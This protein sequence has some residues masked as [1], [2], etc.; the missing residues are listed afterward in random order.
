MSIHKENINLAEYEKLKAFLQTDC[1]VKKQEE[2]QSELI[3]ASVYSVL[4]KFLTKIYREK[5]KNPLEELELCFRSVK[6]EI[7]SDQK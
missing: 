5:P 1:I 4:Q 6:N 3:S 2:D 7:F